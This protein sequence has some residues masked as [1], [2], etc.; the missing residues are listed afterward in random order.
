MGSTG[1]DRPTKKMKLERATSPTTSNSSEQI[2][3]EFAKLYE[4]HNEVEGSHMT[5]PNLH[6]ANPKALGQQAQDNRSSMHN[7]SISNQNI[8]SALA[9]HTSPQHETQSTQETGA[10]RIMAA[11]HNFGKSE[12]IQS[13]SEKAWPRQI[14]PQSPLTFIPGLS[15]LGTPEPSITASTIPVVQVQ[16]SIPNDWPIQAALMNPAQTNLGI[17]QTQS[18]VCGHFA[19]SEELML[20]RHSMNNLLRTLSTKRS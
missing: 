16:S 1:G 9:T 18:E 6:A 19:A 13:S 7:E 3:N 8:Q 10:K 5:R 4:T 17:P 20:T 12:Q 11:G 2:Y 14:T 15:L